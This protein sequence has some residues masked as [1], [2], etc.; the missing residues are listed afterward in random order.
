MC[1]IA[2]IYNYGKKEKVEPLLLKRMNDLLEHRG[3]DDEGFYIKENVGLSMR[4]LAII[5]LST[6]HQP[7]GSEDGRVQLVFNG[8]IYNY[9]ELRQELISQGVRFKT[10]S[11]TEVILRLYEKVGV[12]CVKRLRGMF[13]F[14]IWD[15]THQ[16]L[17]LARDRVGKKPLVYTHDSGRIVWASEIRALLEVPG[18]SKEIDPQAVDLYLGLQYIPSPWTIYK[19]I[20]K[21]P[22]AHCL[23]LEK[24]QTRME[25]YWH[26]P[27]QEPSFSGTFEEAKREIRLKFEESTRLRMIS[28]VPLGAFL[29]GGVD[30]T[31][32]V[33]TMSRLSSR[34]VKTFAIGFQEEK[35]SELAYAKEV[36]QY[37]K[38]DHTEFVVKP[39]MADVLP[40]LAWHY[41]EPYGDSSALPSFYLARETRKHV[42]VALTGDGGDENFAGYRRYVA[43]KMM[44]FLDWMPQNFRRSLSP[45]GNIL[46]RK[47]RRFV[48]D[49]WG[50]SASNRYF[51]TIGIFGENEKKSMYTSDFFAQVGPGDRSVQYLNDVLGKFS[52]L[53]GTNQLLATDFETYLPECLMV[54]MDIATMANSL[55][56]RSPFLDHELIDLAFRFP[57]EWK[58]KGLRGAKWILKQ[59]FSD[60]LP[61]SIAQRSKMG[62]G[63]PLAAWF[64][65]ELRNLWRDQVLSSAALARGYFQRSWLEKMFDEHVS[66]KRDHGYRMWVLL[67]LEMWHQTNL[68]GG[69]VAS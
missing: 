32:V 39:H 3:P 42:T 9:R 48:R 13:A 34:P 53:D 40:K 60:L 22:P 1:G 67:M 15:E 54:K 10:N 52:H 57:V 21:L 59:A 30:S 44:R 5:D 63:I 28:D 26:L 50:A 4:R 69:R 33:G 27:T 56:A 58:L 38:T 2:G 36:A 8:E 65:G 31:L 49:I 24:G 41:G 29:S 62:F 61:A 47:G 6:G 19:A 20:R 64:R 68:P 18:L 17:M 46:P 37:F 25:R 11:D 55:E 16:R 45:V 23:I 35:F 66:G 51:N 12:E 43:M 7:M 14:S